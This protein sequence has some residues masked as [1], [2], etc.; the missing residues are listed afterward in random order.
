[1]KK[2][3]KTDNE[4]FLILESNVRVLKNMINTLLEK[5]N[6]SEVSR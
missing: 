1:L 2:K 5:Q 4:R 6:I 3:I